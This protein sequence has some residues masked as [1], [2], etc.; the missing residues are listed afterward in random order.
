MWG[1]LTVRV[2]LV[3]LVNIH[4]V[5]ITKIFEILQGI[6]FMFRWTRRASV[7]KI[8]LDPDLP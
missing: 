5:E 8:E 3:S 7:T 4:G 2:R 1:I 6:G